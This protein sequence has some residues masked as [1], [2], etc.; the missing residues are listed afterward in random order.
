MSQGQRRRVSRYGYSGIGIDIDGWGYRRHSPRERHGR[1]RHRYSVVKN[2]DG[3]V[4]GIDRLIDWRI[5]QS[6]ALRRSVHFRTRASWE[7]F[8]FGGVLVGGS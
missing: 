4:S 8:S 6:R 2:N 3:E 1:Y 5:N 7:E